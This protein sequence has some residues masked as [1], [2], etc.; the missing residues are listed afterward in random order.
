MQDGQ[1]IIQGPACRNGN[2]PEVPFTV[3]IFE[4]F[5]DV[6][7]F[8][9]EWN[10]VVSRSGSAIYQTFEWC[11]VWWRHYGSRRQ[12]QL[13]LYFAG[14]ELVGIM[15]AFVETLWLGGVRIKVAKLIGSDYS[16]QFCNLAV[17]PGALE[18]SVSSAIRH[19]VED[20]KCDVFVVGPL[21]GPGARMDEILA[22]CR[23][24]AT[25]LQSAECLRGSLSIRFNLPECFPQYLKAIGARQRGNYSRS[26]KRIS[27]D[28]HL[29]TD[30]ISSADVVASE[31]ERFRQLHEKQW[32]SVGRLGHFKDWPMA[33]EFNRDLVEIFGKDGM[34]RFFRILADD[35]VVS[36]QFCFLFEGVN[37]WRLPGRDS[38]PSY[39]DLSLGRMGLIQM[40][41][42]LIA[43]GVNVVEGGRGRYGYK[44]QLGGQEWPV[45]RI[46]FTRS[47][48][49]VGIRVRM[50]RM[51]A[52][53]LDLGYYR[54]FY[55][56]LVPKFSCFKHSLWP[57][58]IRSTW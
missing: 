3:R 43:E 29:I 57:V 47:G 39:A 22:S 33:T 37:Y 45:G 46:Q 42:S 54:V 36:S 41:D 12:L 31:F 44:L 26:K 20:W 9:A 6:E 24:E 32:A 16:V 1:E 34:V 8:R 50:F 52:S 58:W 28:H 25:H 40:I 48:V 10:G 5:A 2:A 17:L 14:S 27:S 4:D 13:L 19:L 49:W 56:R 55:T 38:R 30:T 21:S 11:C 51:L 7:P 35:Q 53:L 15:P 18:A 23:N